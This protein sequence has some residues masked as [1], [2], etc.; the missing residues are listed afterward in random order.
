MGYTLTSL[1][2]EVIHALGKSA[3]ASP[4]TATIHVNDA[5]GWM[6]SSHQWSWLQ[7][8]LSL[9]L[10]DAQAYVAMPSDFGRLL[11]AHRVTTFA[12]LVP[13]SFDKLIQYRAT[14]LSA[15]EGM[16]GFYYCLR[17]EKQASVTAA[18]VWRM[19]LYP[20]PSASETGGIVGIYQRLPRAMTTGTDVP[21]MPDEYHIALKYLCRAMAIQSEED[22]M[23]SDWDRY[24][25]AIAILKQKDG[26]VQSDLGQMEGGIFTHTL[27]S[28]HLYPNSITI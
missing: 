11:V 16:V 3:P 25:E 6:C 27:D 12:R 15:V 18:P 28:A 26:D 1:S 4:L 14:Q 8:D 22:R 24:N 10:V 19:E 21:D 5:V 20:T 23:S 9:N 7:E 17:A 13:V 2:N